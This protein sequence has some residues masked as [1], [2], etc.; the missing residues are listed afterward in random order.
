M[1]N[2][3]KGFGL[4]V[5]LLTSMAVGQAWGQVAPDRV[6]VDEGGG[7]WLLRGETRHRLEP[8]PI[9]PELQGW[10]EG[11]PVGS[12]IPPVVQIE[13]VM[14]EPTPPP[15]TLAPVVIVAPTATPAPQW[16]QVASWSGNSD[17]TTPP[18]SI[19]GSQWRIN[20]T[21]RDPKYSSPQVCVSIRSTDANRYIS[22]GGGCFRQDGESYVYAGPGMFYLDINSSDEWTVKV[23]DY[24]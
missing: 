24:R 14:V 10:T 7:L 11:E 15:P 21:V 1:N 22:T 13:R 5:L 18:F 17:K 9:G 2:G 23:E 6:V 19:S 12:V 3:V 8:A 16:R 4:A 20:Y